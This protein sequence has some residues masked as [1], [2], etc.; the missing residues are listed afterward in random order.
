MDTRHATE[1][2]KERQI[3]R[4]EVLFVLKHGYHEKRKD[5]F[6]EFHQSW[7]YSVRGK[8]VDLREVRVV[9]SFDEN[10][11]LIITAIELNQ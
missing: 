9:V 10:G 8:T 3:T 5:T 1:R 7:N 2:R 6:D 11:M 4:S